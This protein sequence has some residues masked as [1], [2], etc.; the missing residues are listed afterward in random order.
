MRLCAFGADDAGLLERL[1]IGLGQSWDR[2]GTEPRK[3]GDRA[4]AEPSW[5]GAGTKLG[6][7]RESWDRAG[8]ELGQSWGR[9]G[10]E[11]GQS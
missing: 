8:A 2:P 1:G 3:L 4:W 6:Q 10:A 7:S 5:V 9:A 11:L